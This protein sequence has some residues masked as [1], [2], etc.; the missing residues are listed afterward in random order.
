MTVLPVVPWPLLVV[1][2]AALLAAVWWNPADPDTP[3]ESGAAHWRR[4]AAVLLLAVAALRP[5]VGGDEAAATA[6]NLNVYFVVDTTSSIVAE[7]YGESRP[8]LDGIREDIAA[9]AEW[10]PG[11]RYSVVTF[12]QSTRVRLPLTTDTTA[13]EAA[14]ETLQPEATEVSRG[15]SITAARARVQTLLEQAVQRHPERGRI[16]F[17]LGDGEH[18]APEPPAPFAVPGGLVQGGAVLGYGTTEGGR[19]RSTRARYTSSGGYV[20]DP[21]TGEDARSVIDEAAL[22]GIGASL[23]VPYVHRARGESVAPVVAGVDLDRF[24]TEAVEQ[25]K[26]RTRREA[27]WLLLAGVAAL[28]VWELG[29]GLQSLAQTRRRKGPTR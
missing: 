5:A 28:A 4:G 12:D 11:A 19:M 2:G 26:V 10:L 7:D 1:V 18:T 15:T 14:V 21:A 29:A 24:G 27:Y 23:G 25:E 6:A 17:Y 9:I 8:R 13:L 16:V 22:R 20:Q 3:G